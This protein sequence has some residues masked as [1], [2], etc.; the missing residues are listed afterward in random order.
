MNK[1]SNLR[2]VAEYA[3]VSVATAS[4][5]MNTPDLVKPETRKKVNAAIE[6]LRFVPSAAARAINSGRSRF[7]AAL[8]P[9]LDYSIF[10]RFLNALEKR[11][12]EL[13]LSLIVATTDGNPEIE[14]KKAKE[15]INIG[16]EGFIVSGYSH[17][18]D[19]FKLIERSNL[20]TILSSTSQ[21]V[22]GLPSIGYD[23]RASANLAVEHLVA[24]GHKDIAVI[25]GST[26][27]NDRQRERVEAIKRNNLVNARFFEGELSV[28]HGRETVQRVLGENYAATAFLCT[29]DIIAMGAI[30]GV[31]AAGKHVPS[32]YSIVGMED[33]SFAQHS[34]PAL[35][36]VRLSVAKMGEECANVISDWLETGTRPKSITL[37]SELI[38]RDST[39]DRAR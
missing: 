3:G 32:D 13:E 17:N 8:I 22:H 28:G 29:S 23:N 37:N 1:R 11:L 30:F 36:T 2:D 12:S 21:S 38:I 34:N 24:L 15:L 14:A 5:V 35:S 39:F 10:S 16:C 9:T 20:P 31:Q 25:H 27:G 18:A 7:V 33:I 19:F 26:S 6:A 4:R